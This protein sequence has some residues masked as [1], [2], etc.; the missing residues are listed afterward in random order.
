MKFKIVRYIAFLLLI[1]LAVETVFFIKIG[2]HNH[3]IKNQLEEEMK[4]NVDLLASPDS[5]T[6]IAKSLNTTNQISN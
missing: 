6:N 4:T 1:G 5:M 2:M 3:K